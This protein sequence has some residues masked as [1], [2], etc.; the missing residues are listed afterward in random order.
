M[1]YPSA[2]RVEKHSS[3]DVCLRRSTHLLALEELFLP[4][5][6]EFLDRVQQFHTHHADG[7]AGTEDG[8]HVVRI[9]DILQD[10]GQARQSPSEN[11]GDADLAAGTRKQDVLPV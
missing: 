8:A 6:R 11:I 9:V 3:T 5:A 10:H 2:R 7:I 1:R 4:D